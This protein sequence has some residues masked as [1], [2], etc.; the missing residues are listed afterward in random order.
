MNFLK[1]ASTKIGDFVVKSLTEDPVDETLQGYVR[2]VDALS[3]E[4]QGL[5]SNCEE[6]ANAV[7]KMSSASI[8]M[9]SA[10]EKF[11]RSVSEKRPKPVIDFSTQNK[12]LKSFST[13]LFQEQFGWDVLQIFD[14]WESAVETLRKDIKKTD[15]A[16]QKLVLF[17]TKVENARKGKSSPELERDEA[18]LEKYKRSLMKMKAA[19]DA[20]VKK[21]IE[22]RFTTFDGV[23]FRLM[24]FQNEFFGKGISITQKYETSIA[25]Y[26]KKNPKVENR[27]EPFTA[28]EPKEAK[29]K[30]APS[31]PDSDSDSEADEEA[32]SAQTTNN[33][34]HRPSDIVDLNDFAPDDLASSPAVTSA[35]SN[36]PQTNATATPAPIDLLGGAGGAPDFL[37]MFDISSAQPSVANSTQASGTNTP[38]TGDLLD[39]FSTGSSSSSS[40]T[41]NLSQP[42]PSGFE[43]FDT[44]GSSSA[45]SSSA[46]N[47]STNSKRDSFDFFM[48]GKPGSSSAQS[49]T[50]VSSSGFDLIDGG[51]APSTLSSSSNSSADLLQFPAGGGGGGGGGGGSAME[52]LRQEQAAAAKE[53]EE[54]RAVG[55]SVDARLAAW[56]MRNGKKND[57]RGLLSGLHTILWPEA[58]WKKVSLA[59]ML[60]KK[61]VRK[62]Y[63]AA[64]RMLHPDKIPSDSSTEN[65]LI[66]ERAIQRV[67]EAW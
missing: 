65:K 10:I 22:G 40:S 19:L 62:A 39:M 5:K 57:I 38:I 64:C 11:Y 6:Y 35:P 23:L 41:S 55:G 2:M 34:N 7:L 44:L 12:E 47:A 58:K 33:I 50:S 13:H 48:N 60:D 24:E 54:R 14:D 52:T 27:S 37:N 46:A 51:L 28:A 18:N 36:P 16:M 4:I 45:A 43:M 29:P 8:N 32:F 53:A 20:K 67:Q 31:Q 66:G 30:E 17:E 26:R 42:V 63:I 61:A 21:V 49:Q 25:E 1:K 3:K 15:D 56:E 59:D 9:T